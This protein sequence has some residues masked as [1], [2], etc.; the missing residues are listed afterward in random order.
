M[1]REIMT[2]RQVPG[3]PKRRWFM[4]RNADLIVWV[5]ERDSPIGFQ[6]CYDKDTGE[7]ALTWKADSGYSHTAV[8]SGESRP[9]K[10]KETPIL[11]ADGVFDAQRILDDFRRQGKALPAEIVEFVEARMAVLMAG[12]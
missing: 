9:A 8:D 10:Y 1:L 12:R 5:D 4:S 2:A 7:H 3:E 11:V 6:L